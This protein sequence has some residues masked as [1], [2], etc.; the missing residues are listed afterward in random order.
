[1]YVYIFTVYSNKKTYKVGFYEPIDHEF[2]LES[3]HNNIKDAAARVAYLNGGFALNIK[4][5]TPARIENLIKTVLGTIIAKLP[6]LE[7]PLRDLVVKIQSEIKT[8][9]KS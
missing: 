5:P 6:E 1:M 7:A 9:P 8:Q 4:T 3:T 2:V